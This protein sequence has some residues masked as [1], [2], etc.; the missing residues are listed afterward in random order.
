M[1]RPTPETDDVASAEGNWDTRALRM[2][3]HARKLERERD[4]ARNASEAF[5]ALAWKLE[6]ERNEARA[7]A[8]DLA[9]IASHC[10]GWHD[11][12]STDA[13]IRITAA[14]KRWKKSK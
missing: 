3:A 2:T 13:A 14:L 7:I 9:V 8:H 5:S 4:E 12:E 10:L 11:H 6:G 1:S